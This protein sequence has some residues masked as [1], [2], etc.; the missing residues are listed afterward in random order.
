M[1]TRIIS[2]F[3]V[4]D[5]DPF[6]RY[7]RVQD[8]HILPGVAML[9]AV[10]KTFAA[11]RIDPRS[12]TL[13]NVLFHEPVVTNERVDRKLSLTW[14]MQGAHGRITVASVP[15]RDNSQLS[16]RVTTHMTCSVLQQSPFSLDSCALELPSDSANL[17]DCYEVTRRIGIFHEGFMKCSGRV[18]RLDSGHYL[19][20]IAL[21]P[22][23]ARARDF[24]LHPVFLDCST[25]VPL[26]AVREQLGGQGLF[27]P[28]AIER[29][30]ATSLLGHTKLRVLVEPFEQQR[31]DAELVRYRFGM[32]DSRGQGLARVD[33]F[34]VKRVR[35]LESIRDL[36]TRTHSVTSVVP[37]RPVRSTTAAPNDAIR[38][39]IGQLLGQLGNFEYSAKDDERPF[40]D[41]GLS[42]A[43]LL[44][45]V[46]TLETRLQ[47]TLYPTTLF[48]HPNV[49]ALALHL[50][51]TYPDACG[52]VDEA[53]TTAMP[54][55]ETTTPV[56]RAETL[57]PV[58]SDAV[59]VSRNENRP[60][61]DSLISKIVSLVTARA[62]DLHVTPATL[63]RPFFELGLDSNALL[64]VA[65][66]LETQLQI[67]VYPTT[68]FEHPTIAALARHLE[69]EFP[70]T[71]AT[72]VEPAP[73]ERDTPPSA[74]RQSQVVMRP[75][76]VETEGPQPVVTLAPPSS[77]AA[78]VF[79]PR[80][81]P[82]TRE[83]HEIGRGKAM[84]IEAASSELGQRLA[85]RYGARAV[86]RGTA[87]E[88]ET[89]LASNPNFDEVCLLNLDHGA[90]FGVVQALRAAGRLV[91]G[92]TLR[93]VTVGCFQV[94][95][96]AVR[97]DA[98]HGT[99]GLLQ[100][101]SRE[102]PE[103][104]VSGWDI[105]PEDVNSALSDQ[106][107]ATT[108]TRT[109]RA[110]RRDRNYRRILAPVAPA[111]ET[112]GI[113]PPGC[114]ATFVVVGGAGGVGLEWV[115]HLRT[116]YGARVAVIGRRDARDAIEAGLASLPEFGQ[117]VTY[118]RADLN[119]RAALEGAFRAIHTAFGSI[120]CVVHSA[121]VLDDRRLSDMDT[122]CFERVQAPKVAGAQT[123]AKVAEEFGAEHLLFFSAAQAFVGNLGQANYAAA[124]TYVDGLASALRA[125]S[126]LKVTVV[127]W[128]YWGEVGAVASEHYQRL[129][130]RQGVFG[131]TTKD[132]LSRLDE[133]LS[134]G[135]EQALIMRGSEAVLSEM[136]VEREFVITRPRTPA[137]SHPALHSTAPDAPLAA[138]F[139]TTRLAIDQLA[140][141]GL[142]R[143][144]GVLAELEI[145]RRPLAAAHA[146]LVPVLR[147]L[148]H[149]Y[150]ATS[151]AE[152]V[153][154][155]DALASTNPTL[156]ALVP[157]LRAAVLAYPDVLTG[158]K[159][160]MVALFPGGR[161]DLVRP[162]YADSNVSHYFNTVTASAV[163]QLAQQSSHP[164]R[165]LEVG[166]GTGATTR[167]ILDA[168]R[169]A[170][171]TCEYWYTELWDALLADARTRLGAT[172]P[173]LRFACLDAGLDPA[174][175]GFVGGNYDVVVATNVL[176]ATRDVRSSVRHLKKLLRPGGTL[177]VNES[178]TTQTYSTLTFGLLPGW[179]HA[180][181]AEQR[182]PNSPLLDEQR[183]QNTLA[184]EGFVGERGLVA[185]DAQGEVPGGQQVFVAVSDGELRCPYVASVEVAVRRIERTARPELPP[186]LV[187][188]L[189]EF[190][191]R[192]APR[193][194]RIAT[195]TDHRD[196]IWVFMN[197]A[198]AN[199]F[200][201]EF[202]AELCATL[203]GIAVDVE[204]RGRVVYL[205]HFG[206]YF[207]LGGD[208][209]ELVK[210]LSN[211]LAIEAFADKVRALFRTITSLNAIVVA[212]V[213]GT[214]QGGGM[215][216]LFAT[217]LQV[218]RNGVKLGLPE[219]R[220]GLIPGM[221]GLTQLQSVL[222]PAR[223][224]RLV[225]L[226]ELVDA[227]EALEL[228]MVSH[229]ADDPF[230]SALG[231]GDS[232][233]HLEAAL[234]MKRI[235]RPEVAN[236]LCADIDAWARYL[237]AH[238]GVI[239]A[240]RIEN[241]RLLVSGRAAWGVRR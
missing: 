49:A 58:A 134:S 214:A 140:A 15:W 96:E 26:L 72:L 129:L 93:S 28:I 220:S 101:T 201:D 128:G 120:H 229:V 174:T 63:E 193:P 177:V 88:F 228:G 157:L 121:M 230:T 141:A 24:Q 167:A 170:D 154:E 146:R 135:V 5:T 152:F 45:A 67:R 183:W 204:Q 7:H 95:D 181:D 78:Q 12:I 35:S 216:T 184:D 73:V 65:D 56:Q 13:E 86:F 191:P 156:T 222:G 118:H 112:A 18:G 110:R 180:V 90:A 19:G 218:V 225:L 47:V 169:S 171:S 17:D 42:S 41:L 224:K 211:P 240:R 62:P 83:P 122:A 60:A 166:A 109:L 9:D 77:E 113:A 186:A 97:L 81:V 149:G 25:I 23:A 151:E 138:E 76:N 2:K 219:V 40:F 162:V 210:N 172:Y 85:E 117:E 179:W 203:Q 199:M 137:P 48:E 20:E 54:L 123:L 71:C 106:I 236:R 148:S 89:V 61:P 190:E 84:L 163:Q 195:Y 164:L 133:V 31:T 57:R 36:L 34:T 8:I 239:D 125:T 142:R 3:S 187:G 74:P 161:N 6:V 10:Y 91:R 108:P 107:L 241:S 182:L 80:W 213:N 205:S 124:S 29:F 82:I 237:G 155:V 144:T 68:L 189:R 98:P 55:R 59:K 221:G 69:S 116:H 119:D 208:R 94:H 22:E 235:L 127:N 132:A 126:S 147:S 100:T 202:L 50:R 198:P 87:E 115:R 223:T 130:A 207:S 197:N 11:R 102:Y 103:I 27:I 111:R 232:L 185:A 105:Q 14:D 150:S 70:D 168:L 51:E 21:G 52:R 66:D 139:E 178:I 233:K 33:N 176:H 165:I 217:D 46:E 53:Q 79:T 30:R 206:E 153:A 131:M 226:G 200:D 212:V 104:T 75:A 238:A 175:Q 159:P 158:K 1:G 4:K 209:S 92:L 44:E 99:W 227:T 136:H 38:S 192:T 160:A 114:G 231:I 215:E 16:D 173:E 143:V 32:F 39:L 188:K 196:N 43:E 194:R 145:E 64:E 37:E 234:Q